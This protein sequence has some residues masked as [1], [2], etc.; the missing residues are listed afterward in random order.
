MEKHNFGNDQVG[1]IA[2]L[3][4]IMFGES[5]NW[6]CKWP[7]SATVGSAYIPHLVRCNAQYACALHHH[8]QQL[9]AH[10]QIPRVRS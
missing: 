8:H 6:Q 3:E 9:S 1:K 4:I 5:Q 2:T 10:A 7:F